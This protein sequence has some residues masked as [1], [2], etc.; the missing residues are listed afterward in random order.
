MAT[1]PIAVRQ[2]VF[3]AYGMD[4][5]QP[6]EYEVDHLITPELGGT[7]DIRNLW[8]EP[9]ASTEWNAYVKDQLENHLRQ[10]VCEGKLDLSTAQRDIATDWISA[11]RRY[12]HTEKPLTNFSSVIWAEER[13]PAD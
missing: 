3:H 6:R 10:M 9:Y 12:F 2:Q 5:S 11:Y 7:D 13:R 8:P 1:I 4:H